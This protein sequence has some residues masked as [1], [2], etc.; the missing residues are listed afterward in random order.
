MVFIG[1]EYELAALESQYASNCFELS[2]VY[3]RRRV[4]KTY[5]IHHFLQHHDGAYMVGLESGAANNLEALSQAVY[6]ATGLLAPLTPTMNVSGDTVSKAGLNRPL[7]GI[8]AMTSLPPFPS[9]TAAMRYLFEYSLEHRVVFVIDEYSYIAESIP[10]ISSELQALIDVYRERSQLFLILCGSS[11]SFMEHQVLGH[12]SPLYG[13][14]TAQY[15]V[16]PFNYLETRQMVSHLSLIES[17]I[18]FGITGGVAEYV[19]Y[20]QS[21]ASLDSSIIHLFFNPTG[22]LVDEPSSLLKQELREPRQYNSILSAIAKGASRNN[23]IATAVGLQTG[24]LNNYLKNLIDLQIIEKIAPVGYSTNK[25]IYKIKDSMYTFW[26]RFVEPNQ[27]AIENFSGA[28]V[29]EQYVKPLLSYFMGPVF[30]TMAHQYVGLRMQRQQMPFLPQELGH[31]WGA[32]PEMKQQM[33]IDLVALGEH[34]VSPNEARLRYVLTGECK[35]RNEP[36][37]Q[38]VLPDLIYKSRLIQGMHYYWLFSKTGFSFA[39]MD[40]YVELVS[41]EDMYELH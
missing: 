4:G 21:P 40:D 22:R 15:R 28:L 10:S 25:S 32:D 23:E 41:L 24:A 19:S 29:Y 3:G 34:Q 39:S 9:V 20:F 14:R 33:E 16:K 2:I 6:R 8:P 11:M 12:K 18:V 26:Y 31:W 36:V 5:L 17:S 1:R 27:G 35:W 30:E 7:T 13:R 37:S 38:T